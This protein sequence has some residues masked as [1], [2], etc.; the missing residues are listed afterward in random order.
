MTLAET[1]FQ[2]IDQALAHVSPRGQAI[3]QREYIFEVLT[4]VIIRRGQINLP[5]FMQ[6]PRKAALHEAHDV[7]HDRLTGRRGDG[8]TRTPGF[9]ALPI[10]PSPRLSISISLRLAQSRR[11]R[12]QD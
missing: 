12:K 4:L 9:S 3:D 7:S 10:S 2:R 6:Q 8:A 5:A 1:G 11:R